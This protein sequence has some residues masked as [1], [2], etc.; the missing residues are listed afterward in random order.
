MKAND[1]TRDDGRDQNAGASG[2]PPS[3]I[4]HGNVSPGESREA[5]PMELIAEE[6]A[7]EWRSGG[8]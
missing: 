2:A 6:F 1:E 5:D 7:R 4:D 8:G 3:S